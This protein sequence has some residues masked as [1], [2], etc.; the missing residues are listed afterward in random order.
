MSEL[1]K[2]DQIAIALPVAGFVLLV[3]AYF[4]IRYSDQFIDLPG[5]RQLIS[6]IAILIG[7]WRSR[8]P[9]KWHYYS[10]YD[11]LTLGG[12]P[13]QSSETE[14]M[15]CDGH[16]GMQYGLV[17]SCLRDFETKGSYLRCW[18]A[19]PV[20][21]DEWEARGIRYHNL[22]I[23]DMTTLVGVDDVLA[24]LKKINDCIVCDK[25]C[26]YLHCQAGQGRSFFI[27]MAYFMTYGFPQRDGSHTVLS[28]D[29][30]LAKILE[31]RWQVD[32]N[33]RRKIKIHEIVDAFFQGN[34]NPFVADQGIPPD[35]LQ[36]P[37]LALG[38]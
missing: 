19:L 36:L 16:D 1:K 13:Y 25:K 12:G 30:A 7:E 6:S 38:S 14:K 10:H 20:Q 23:Q 26:V 8:D 22:P 27:C 29:D 34:R 11:M 31:K 21:S 3:L 9:E 5:I 28:Y 2:T 24:T 32:A 33:E 35:G 37:N 15:I 17:V 18:H 4:S